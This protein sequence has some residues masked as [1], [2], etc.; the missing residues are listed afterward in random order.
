M[1]RNR[2]TAD[3]YEVGYRKPPKHSRFKPGRSGNLRG[4]PKK[5]KNLRSIIRATLFRKIKVMEDGHL[6]TMNRVE[7]IMTNMVAKALKGDI[8][9][10]EAV[11]RLANQHFP[12]GQDI[13]L[14]Q[15]FIQR[16]SDGE[17]LGKYETQP[18][19]EQK[20][21]PYQK[22]ARSSGR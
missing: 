8:R 5:A 10:S 21:V 9:A 12:P 20:F 18:D 14:A 7:A 13:E 22:R 15:I 19:S 16:L 3:D 17:I 11:L 4:R 2:R 1:T 6:R